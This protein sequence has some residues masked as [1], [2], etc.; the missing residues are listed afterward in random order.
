MKLRLRRELARR[1]ATSGKKERDAGVVRIA[2]Q[3]FSEGAGDGAR[4]APGEEEAVRTMEERGR[5]VV[6]AAARFGATAMVGVA[7]LFF[8]LHFAHL[9]A[10]FPNNSPW[11]DW[12]KYTDEGWYGDAAIRHFERGSWHV[13]GDF[14][15]GAALPVW[16]V[17]EG[18]VFR[19]TGV[20]I[21]PARA[22]TVAVFGLTL[23]CVYL[24][25]RRRRMGGRSG[26]L[27]PAAAV[28]LLAVNP[29]CYAFTRLAILEPLLN[30]L[31][32]VALLV[33]SEIRV[34]THRGGRQLWPYFAL[35]VLLPL[36][37]LT[38]TTA[39]FLFPAVLWMMLARVNYRLGTLLR[40]G[41]ISAVTGRC[42]VADVLRPPGAP[43]LSCGL[44][45]PVQCECVYGHHAGELGAGL[46][47]TWSGTGC[48]SGRCLS[49]WR[50]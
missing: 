43:P 41:A 27:V 11:V 15:P 46:A 22:L 8:C 24:L 6:A 16:P 39:I 25:L 9:R 45:V 5:E 1:Q 30:L 3:G 28:L 7:L 12:A 20:G 37:V 44:P 14:N 47:E 32:A 18:L 21:V 26:D 40:R 33:A 29:F 4:S 2:S 19:F 38:K 42:A 50:S 17:L 48:G 34:E 36:M 13:P 35:G 23:V 31:M 10:D 49:R